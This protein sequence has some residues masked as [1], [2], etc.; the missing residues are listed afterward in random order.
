MVVA[1]G[2]GGG[3][4]GYLYVLMMLMSCFSVTCFA[5]MVSVCPSGS[6]VWVNPC[7]CPRVMCRWWCSFCSSLVIVLLSAV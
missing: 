3:V 7:G 1:G 6:C 5:E 4:C 2:G